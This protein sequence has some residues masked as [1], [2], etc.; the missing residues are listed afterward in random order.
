MQ[1]NV[2]VE[3]ANEDETS[4]VPTMSYDFAMLRYKIIKHEEKQV[5]LWIIVYF[6]AGLRIRN[7][8]FRI[9]IRIFYFWIADP[10]PTRVKAEG[11]ASHYHVFGFCHHQQRW[12]NCAW[13]NLINIFSNKRGYKNLFLCF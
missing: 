6:S 10:D 4:D 12:Q 11:V 3:P 5:I 13:K 8:L 2:L 9:R 7:D 1:D